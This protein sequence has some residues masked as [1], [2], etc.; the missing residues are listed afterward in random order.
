MTSILPPLQ[1]PEMAKLG[2]SPTMNCVLEE[3][4]NFLKDTQWEEMQRRSH[5]CKC[6]APG[7]G[8]NPMPERP[9]HLK[10]ARPTASHKES[11]EVTQTT[12]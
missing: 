8:G 5:I 4:I 3:A 6:G 7:W 2:E 9:P 1:I 12:E 10:M 11:S